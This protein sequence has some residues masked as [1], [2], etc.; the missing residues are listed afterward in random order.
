M[1]PC[2][3]NDSFSSPSMIRPLL[4]FL[5][6]GELV[7]PSEAWH[8]LHGKD[9][10]AKRLV[11]FIED[12]EEPRRLLPLPHASVLLLYLFGPVEFFFDGL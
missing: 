5:L 8:R 2:C 11:S 7:N 12:E 9:L 3:Q 6:N 4:T 1:A 10:G